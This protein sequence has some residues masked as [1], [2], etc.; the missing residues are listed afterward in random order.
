MDHLVSP[1]LAPCIDQMVLESQPPY[2]SVNLL[3]SKVTV[4]NKLIILWES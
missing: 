3:H 1:H 2:T 4:N